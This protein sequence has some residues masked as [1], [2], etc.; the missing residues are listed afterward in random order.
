M[1]LGY[2]TIDG[3]TYNVPVIS[4]DRTI[5]TLDLFAERTADGVL[6]RQLIGVFVNY[7]V[8]WGKPHTSSVLSTYASLWQALAQAVPFHTCTMPDGYSFTCYIGDGAKDSI[9]RIKSAS[10]WWMSLSAS[11]IAQSPDNSE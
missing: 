8:A 5:N 11:F 10:V 1:T 6:H 3:T 4:C 7:A 9:N 2:V